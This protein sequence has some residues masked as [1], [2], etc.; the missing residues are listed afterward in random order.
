MINSGIQ[1]T[2]H[3]WNIAR[4]CTKV[5][6]DCKFCYMY[7]QSLNGTRY[8]PKAVVKTKTVFRLPLNVKIPSKFFVSSLT[9]PWHPDIDPYRH[10][11]W[12]IIRAC[13]QH[14]FQILTKR[15][16]LIKLPLDWDSVGYQNVWIGTS[17]GHPNAMH[18]IEK[19]VEKTN[20]AKVV[21]LSLEP[22]WGELRDFIPIDY[23]DGAPMINW[24]IVG[25]ESGNDRGQY[26][27]RECKL[28]WIERIVQE[29]RAA[30]VPVFVKQLGTHLAKKLRLSDR[31]GG[32]IGE[33][34]KHLQIREFP[35][36]LAA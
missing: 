2:D 32:N 26:R 14:T 12:E 34:P 29:C 36:T 28:E 31:H 5:D 7:R 30:G 33:W 1:W 17:V 22:L 16:E 8:N 3:T 24:V 25:G 23:A 4:G 35:K 20:N 15:P 10:E 9:D 6:E 27:Y 13:P 18:R 19:L 11:M 21:F